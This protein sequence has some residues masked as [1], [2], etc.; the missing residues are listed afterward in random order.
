[1]KT[2]VFLYTILFFGLVS[3]NT[4]QK[5]YESNNYDE[6]IDHLSNAARN[7]SLDAKQMDILTKSYHQANEQDHERIVA[8]KKSGEPD[9]WV[10]IYERFILIQK[11]QN[12]AGRF[13]KEV[14]KSMSYK[15]LDLDSEIAISKEKASSYLVA[16]ANSLLKDNC[17]EEDAAQAIKCINKLQVIDPHNKNLDRLRLDAILVSAN[18]IIMRVSAQDKSPISKTFKDNLFAFDEDKIKEIPFDTAV[19]DTAKYDLMI[20]ISITGTEVS[21]E[22][23]DAVTFDEKSGDA[24]AKVTDK[25]LT[26]TA[27]IRGTI[28]Y[29]KI[30]DN[31]LILSTPFDI[32]S[33][34]RYNYAVVSGDKNAC[35]QQTLLLEERG[36]MGFPSSEALFNDAGRKLNAMLVGMWF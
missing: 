32:T 18:H 28:D 26:K 22:R 2:R 15:R 9:I 35:S 7:G 16:K 30:E 14:K 34:F 5:L 19:N 1:M 29:I 8:L 25:T 4:T 3:C 31:K 33:T 24:V 21:P 36:D 27:T 20:W 12:K 11:R 17:P 13:A 10:E 6:V 23:I